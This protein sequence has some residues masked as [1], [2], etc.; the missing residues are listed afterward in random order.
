MPVIGAA[1]DFAQNWTGQQAGKDTNMNRDDF[2]IFQD[3][4]GRIYAY[5]AD[6]KTAW[7]YIDKA[8]KLGLR[9]RSEKNG[10]ATI[11]TIITSK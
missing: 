9:Y 4:A 8:I 5:T 11:C 2:Y 3:E 1:F 6:S 10:I 7:E